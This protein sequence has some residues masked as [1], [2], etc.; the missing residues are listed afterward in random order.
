M[1]CRR[2]GERGQVLPLA[3]ILMTGLIAM[4]ALLFTSG[5]ALRYRRQLQDASDAAA[6]AAA[7]LLVAQNGCSQAGNGGSPRSAI[8]TAAR[9]SVSTNLPRYNLSDVAVTC[10]TGYSNFA[11]KVTLSGTASSWFGPNG[12]NLGST[13][14]AINGQTGGGSYSVALLDPSNPSWRSQRNGCPSYEINGGVTVTYEGSIFVNSAC[15]RSD[16]LNAA[17]KGINSAFSMRMIN[18]SQMY[19]VGEYASGTAGH[20]TPDPI[21][22]TWPPLGDPL[23]GLIKPCH[24]TDGTSCLGTTGTLPARSMA[25]SGQGSGSSQCKQGNTV[26]DPCILLPGTY[27]GGILAGTGS[28]PTTLLLRPGVYYIEGGGL[29]LKSGSA[30]IIS[31]PAAGTLSDTLARQHYATSRTDA[32]VGAQWQQ[33][34]PAPVVGN[35]NP[36]T[37]GVMIY[38]AKSDSKSSWTT[39]GGNADAVSNGAQ[40]VLLLRSYNPNTDSLGAGSTFNSY[41]NLV[42]WQARS[43]APGSSSPQPDV[44]M[45]G[46]ACVTL[47]GT[48]YAP[49]GKVL[50]GGASCGASGGADTTTTLQFICW[51]LSLS[52]NNNFYFA[53]RADAFTQPM[54]YGLVE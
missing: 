50:F 25:T 38:N 34:C 53:F 32:Q 44:S 19:I 16:S 31:I 46:G 43:P 30:R 3:A 48:V 27:S 47:S 20:I 14:T 21:Q 17:L 8:V 35:P 22:N 18:N 11:V 36:S 39:S 6:L 7:N 12:L 42:V 1:T 33:D 4:V 28:S 37:C 26:L 15:T 9:N 24:A 51:D 41:K 54:G 23:G 52:G 49:G 40:G 10:P 29:Q 2:D 45:A 5:E 13:S